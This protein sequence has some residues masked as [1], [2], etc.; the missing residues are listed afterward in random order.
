MLGLHGKRAVLL[1]A[2]GFYDGLMKWLTV[3]IEQR[4]VQAEALATVHVVQ[5]VDGALDVIERVD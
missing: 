1:D 5:T 4:F 3:A 2:D